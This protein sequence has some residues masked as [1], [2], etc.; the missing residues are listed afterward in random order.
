MLKSNE[1]TKQNNKRQKIIKHDYLLN[2]ML[3]SSITCNVLV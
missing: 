3:F 1:Q 2:S